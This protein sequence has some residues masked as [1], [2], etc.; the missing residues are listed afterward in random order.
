MSYASEIAAKYLD[1][2]TANGSR[3]KRDI[4]DAIAT[5]RE[6]CARIAIDYAI[7]ADGN[8]AEVHAAERIAALIRSRGE[9]RE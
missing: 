2:R 5:E 6:A 4:E 3:L 7:A 1:V 9:A 8:S